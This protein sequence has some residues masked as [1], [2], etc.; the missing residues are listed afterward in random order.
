[1]RKKL[2]RCGLPLLLLGVVLLVA[3]I[4]SHLC[5]HNAYLAACVVLI[6]LGLVGY[7]ADQKRRSR[8]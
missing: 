4:P 7:V 6:I 2:F 5:D 1:M 3:G 8:Y